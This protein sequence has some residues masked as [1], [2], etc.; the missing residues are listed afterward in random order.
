MP[1]PRV[2][3]DG[4]SVSVDQQS[5]EVLPE[6]VDTDDND[7]PHADASG[8]SEDESADE[9]EAPDAWVKGE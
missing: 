4:L 2:L 9:N 1:T 8:D 6:P 3:K 5:D 7:L